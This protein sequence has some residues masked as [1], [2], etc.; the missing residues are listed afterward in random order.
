MKDSLQQ[1]SLFDSL[2]AGAKILQNVAIPFLLVALGVWGIPLALNYFFVGFGGSFLDF[3]SFG[4]MDFNFGLFLYQLFWAA[5]GFVFFMY[6]SFLGYKEY[7]GADPQH[8][9]LQSTIKARWGTLLGSGFLVFLIHLGVV[10]GFLLVSMIF[11]L[12][13][14]GAA[15][16]FSL[17]ISLGLLATMAHINSRL[18]FVPSVALFEDLGAVDTLKRA[19]SLSLGMRWQLFFHYLIGLS[20]AIITFL[21]NM[22]QI[23]WDFT[24]TM[25]PEIFRMLQNTLLWTVI[26]GAVQALILSPI[27]NFSTTA[28]YI[29]ARLKKGEMIHGN[30]PLDFE[31]PEEDWDPFT[32]PEPRDD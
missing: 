27:M 14:G 3:T 21:Y 13:G 23:R 28:L 6:T 12:G 8:G 16:F 19:A 24:R 32:N 7:I 22:I 31:E 9:D 4:R 29:T 2:G 30:D 1:T 20:V 11:S 5:I 10:I 26:S 17:V 25:G 18:Y 15:Q